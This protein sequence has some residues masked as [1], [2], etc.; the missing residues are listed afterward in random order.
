MSVSTNP[1]ASGVRHAPTI[2]L[3]TEEGQAIDE[4]YHQ[5]RGC[6]EDGDG[7][8][9]GV[10]VVDALS[11]L[12]VKFGYVVG[13]PYTPRQA[14]GAHGVPAVLDIAYL[15]VGTYLISP[16]DRRYCIGECGYD[17]EGGYLWVVSVD[18]DGYASKPG[19]RLRR[20][21]AGDVSGW[22]AEE[23]GR[24]TAAERDGRADV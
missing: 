12:F 24:Q 19:G 23:S 11:Q 7:G 15:E 17:D 5:V 4:L 18:A 10:D 2:D 13:G 20:L 1:D 22:T 8:W 6:I 3:T 14:G 9:N 16:T 21:R